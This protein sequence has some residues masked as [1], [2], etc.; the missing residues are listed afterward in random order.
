MKYKISTEQLVFAWGVIASFILFATTL[1]YEIKQDE[2]QFNSVAESIFND[3]ASAI[4]DIKKT[5]SEFSTLFY[6]TEEVDSSEFKFLAGSILRQNNFVESVYYAEKV[7]KNNLATYQNKKRE[8]GFS[9]FKVESF[10]A[11]SISDAFLFPIKFI[12]PY[13]ARSSVWFGKDVLTASVFSEG[14]RSALFNP[15]RL[16][17][18]PSTTEKDKIYAMQFLFYGNNDKALERELKD[19]FGLLL[20]KVDLNK[21][22]SAG[23]LEATDHVNVHFNATSIPGKDVP[24]V[25]RAFE[26]VFTHSRVI[27]LVPEPLL[28]SIY[29]K[30]SVLAFKLAL[31]LT[32]LFVGLLLTLFIWY[33]LNSH[34]THNK[35][36]TE[37]NNIIEGEVALKTKELKLKADELSAAYNRQLALT[38]ELEAFSYSVSHDLRAP[39]RTLDG[40]SRALAE[41]YSE[42]LDPVAQDYLSRICKASERMGALIDALLSLS[43]IT[44]QGLLIEH[45]SVSEL[46]QAVTETMR[47][48][49]PQ[50]EI[51][52]R[53]DE[54]PDIKGDKSLIYVVID[55][56]LRNSWK[57]TKNTAKP[58]IEVGMK[59]Q[60]GET[61]YYVKDNGAGFDMAYA[62]RLFGSFQRLHHQSEFEGHGIG[63]ATAKRIILRHNGKIWAEAEVDKGAVFYFTLPQT[64]NDLKNY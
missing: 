23:R 18:V 45:F 13:T 3:I 2:L 37:Q 28:I 35:L 44:R 63:L 10:D 61:V 57:Y 19:T 31:P 25:N 22:Y 1:N 29:R 14:L 6:L 59:E 46:A 20:Y 41:D 30:K 54:L 15:N 21:I 64:S 58:V 9:G 8:Q 33:V 12:E 52:I 49:E 16:S 51:D 50:R 34:I 5:N 56:L 62:E 39:L 11:K 60:Q 47:E 42:N 24:A 17:F 40:F 38:E 32:V 26:K 48:E 53:I 7:N 36:L 43:R 55:N 4:A 27:S